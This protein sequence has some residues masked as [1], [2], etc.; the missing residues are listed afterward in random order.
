MDNGVIPKK[1]ELN[2]IDIHEYGLISLAKVS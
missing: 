2:G 1:N